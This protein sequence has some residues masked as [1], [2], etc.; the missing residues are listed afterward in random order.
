M[1]IGCMCYCCGNVNVGNVSGRHRGPVLAVYSMAT[2][3]T[4]NWARWCR[5]YMMTTTAEMHQTEL[6]RWL[7]GCLLLGHIACIGEKM[8]P[9]ATGLCVCL[10]VGHNHEPCI[11]SW[12]NRDVIWGVDFGGPKEPCISWGPG[13][14]IGRGSFVGISRPIMKYREYSSWANDIW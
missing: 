12:T 2:V 6:C 7:T 13:S 3:L 1:W 14:H 9:I 11:N 5:R 8:Q 4:S 10:S